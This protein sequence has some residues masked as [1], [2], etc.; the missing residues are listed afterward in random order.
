MQLIYPV[1]DV[2]ISQLFGPS[3]IDYSRFGLKGHNGIDFSGKVGDEILAAADGTVIHVG[4]E[5][6]G[7]GHFILIDH[8]QHVGVY[9]HLKKIL[10]NV[11]QRVF[12]GKQIAEMGN[13]GNSTGPHLHFGIRPKVYDRNDGY[14]GYVDPMPFF[15][16][17]I[18]SDNSNANESAVEVYPTEP[19]GDVKLGRV[20]IIADGVAIRAWAGL[21][22]LIYQRANKGFVLLAADTVKP[23]DGLNWRLC[24]LPCYV[25][26]H[27]GKSK[28]IETIEE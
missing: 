26:E 15:N 5:A 3:P 10:V 21:T 25:A 22:A 19:I 4:Y 11:G 17:P 2:K 14:G 16:R 13:S 6:D 1:R 9:A 20:E 24:F 7:Y 23:A 8:G 18:F 12:Q 28:L 27:D